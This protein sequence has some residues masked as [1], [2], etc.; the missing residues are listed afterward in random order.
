MVKNVSNS[1]GLEKTNTILHI[2]GLWHDSIKDGLSIVR[3][4]Q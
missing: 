1:F 2:I 3:D 4:K